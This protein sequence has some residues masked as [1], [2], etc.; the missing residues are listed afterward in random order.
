MS[1]TDLIDNIVSN[2]TLGIKKKPSLL[3]SLAVVAIAACVTF[4]GYSFYMKSKNETAQPPLD[5]G[6]SNPITQVQAA[7]VTTEQVAPQVVMPETAPVAAVPE[8]PVPVVPATTPA[9]AL[10]QTS[11]VATAAVNPVQ[12]PV[13]QQSGQAVAPITVAAP[14]A[15]PAPIA[16]AQAEPTVKPLPA[17]ATLAEGEAVVVKPTP[18]KRKKPV[19]KTVAK[20]VT[21]TAATEQSASFVE[22]GVSQEEIIVFQKD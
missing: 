20:A 2:E 8:T 17:S 22:E 11:N 15:M 1:E 5:L 10:T 14:V 18:I 19:K 9:Q 3:K 4:L 6:Q 12:T 13:T 21:S 7:P 16:A